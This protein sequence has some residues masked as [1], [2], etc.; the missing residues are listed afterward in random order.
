MNRVLG[1]VLGLVTL[2]KGGSWHFLICQ[3]GLDD[4]SSCLDNFM[5]TAKILTEAMTTLNP[6]SST[7]LYHQLADLLLDRIHRGVYA[8]GTKIPSEPELARTFGIGRPT[9]R[10]A[11]DQLIRQRCLERRRGSG[12]FVTE[13]PEQVDLFMLAGTMASFQ[14]GGV[15]V[16]TTLL[17]RPRQVL[18]EAEQHEQAANPFAGRTAYFLSRRSKVRK[19]PVLLEEIWL[20]PVHFPGL[21][22]QALAGRSLAE[23]ADEQYGLRP[24]SADQTFRID[25]PGADRARS[26]GLSNRDSV[27]VVQRT[28]HFPQVRG[29]I[30]AELYCRTDQLVFSQ[31]LTQHLGEPERAGEK[32]HE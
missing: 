24:S 28:L 16:T 26:L 15:E 20:D 18:V 4:Q 13:P 8:L 30:Y 27:L 6:Q 1:D 29:G 25:R 12:T 17:Q 32:L 11:T 21:G 2:S 5:G 14:K 7:P 19:V 10:Q 3:G 22:R 9:V 31:T 23:L